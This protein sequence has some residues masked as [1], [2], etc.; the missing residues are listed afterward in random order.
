MRRDSVSEIG[1]LAFPNTPYLIFRKFLKDSGFYPEP[2][3]TMQHSYLRKLQGAK[4]LIQIVS[5]RIRVK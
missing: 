5:Q 3:Q 1:K 4:M 2:F